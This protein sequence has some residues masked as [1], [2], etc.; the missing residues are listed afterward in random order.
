LLTSFLSPAYSGKP[1]LVAENID[2]LSISNVH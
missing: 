1:S 2:Y